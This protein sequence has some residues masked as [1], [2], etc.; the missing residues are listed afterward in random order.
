MKPTTLSGSN[1]K[2]KSG[3]STTPPETPKDRI[4]IGG[5]L[6]ASSPATTS[7]R[8]TSK[9]LEVSA[10]QGVT[11]GIHISNSGDQSVSAII[12]EVGA[13]LMQPS[14]ASSMAKTMV[15]SSLSKSRSS[16]TSNNASNNNSPA[17]QPSKKKEKVSEDF[18]AL[19][20]PQAFQHRLHVNDEYKWDGDPS[21]VIE[22]KDKVGEGAYGAVYKAAYINTDWIMAVKMV[23]FLSSQQGQDEVRK[24][25]NVLKKCRHP[26]IVSYF[27]C[28]MKDSFLWIFMEFCEMG[29]VGRVLETFHARQQSFTEKQIAV[30]L[31]QALQGLAHLHR[32]GIKV[33]HRDLKADNILISEMG[34]VKL[35]DFGIAFQQTGTKSKAQTLI[36]T[37]LFMSP[38]MLDGERYN[39]K[40]D[41]WSLGITAIEMAD[42]RPPYVRDHPMRALYRIVHEDPPTVQDPSRWSKEFLSFIN[43][44]LQKNPEQ[45]PTA[46]TLLEHEFIKQVKAEECA[47]VILGLVEQYKRLKEEKAEAERASQR[48][49]DELGHDDF[50]LTSTDSEIVSNFNLTTLSDTID[51]EAIRNTVKKSP[52]GEKKTSDSDDSDDDSD[53]D[54]SDNDSEH[55]SESLSVQVVSMPT[56]NINTP[57]NTDT[58][59]NTKTN[60]NTSTNTNTNT[61]ININTSTNTNTNNENTSESASASASAT[62]T[63]RATMMK[64]MK[65][66]SSDSAFVSLTE[67]VH[68]RRAVS[69]AEKE[70]TDTVAHQLS[71]S[72]QALTAKKTT[73]TQKEMKGLT[74]AQRRDMMAQT[75]GSFVFF[76]GLSVGAEKMLTTV[77]HSSMPPS[78]ANNNNN[79]NNNTTLAVPSPH[80]AE[81]KKKTKKS[82]KKSLG[83]GVPTTIAE[84]EKVVPDLDR[85]SRLPFVELVWEAAHYR[86]RCNE[87]EQEVKALKKDNKALKK[88]ASA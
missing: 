48:E 9:G 51:M 68:K 87:L 66:N 85:F 79:N 38:E 27:G 42:G 78:P 28:A 22:L 77:K 81:P 26:N 8:K 12:R 39:S 83:V 54:D 57:T 46:P 74:D 65:S 71:N 13:K 49:L 29:S 86:E 4:I 37:P 7:K 56:P 21:L 43:V 34:L 84:L 20:A 44:C 75:G 2:C 15:E 70:T 58:D 3:D 30:I 16:N 19:S 6:A 18:P 25:I 59:T 63:A 76:T 72:A 64:K 45:R 52:Q 62:A 61:R 53:S 31:S 1:D 67:T 14:T 35:A 23:P 17:H 47:E 24:E 73:T 33:I 10:P 82:K 32:D 50:R 55:D 5:N 11:P 88:K 40:T 69:T 41:I 60:T 36:G 80:T